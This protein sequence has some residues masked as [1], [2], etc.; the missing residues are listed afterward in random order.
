MDED[1][2][3]AKEDAIL[4]KNHNDLLISPPNTPTATTPTV[5]AEDSGDSP[6]AGN[7]DQA[8][9]EMT[10]LQRKQS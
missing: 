5:R 8:W 4:G 10:E 1:S 3:S 7:D 9:K 6:V 2:A